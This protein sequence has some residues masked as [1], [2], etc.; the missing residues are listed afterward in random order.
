MRIF[1][2]KGIQHT[3]KPENNCI[4]FNGRHSLLSNDSVSPGKAQVV[5]MEIFDGL[6]LANIPF[7]FQSPCT[8]H[9]K[10]AYIITQ[11]NELD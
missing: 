11:A 7:R 6:D 4:S 2:D 3:L 9:S 5:N 10:E 8:G 1:K